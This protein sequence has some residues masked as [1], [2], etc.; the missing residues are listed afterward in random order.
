MTVVSFDVPITDNNILESNM[1]FS[2]AIDPS[3]LPNRVTVSDPDQASVTVVD[4]DGK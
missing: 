1:N 2:I 3:S 4:D